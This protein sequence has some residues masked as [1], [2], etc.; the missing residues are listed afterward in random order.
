MEHA[1]SGPM[2][3]V[4]IRTAVPVDTEAVVAVIL[5]I[6]QEEFGIPITREAQ[7]DL[8]RIADYYQVRDGNFW[9]AEAGGIIVGTI[10]L[11]DI[12]NGEGALRKMFVSAPWRGPEARVAQ[13]LLEELLTWARRKALRRICLGT[14]DRFLAAHRFYEKHGFELIAKDN[15]PASFPVMTVDTRF[16]ALRLD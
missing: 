7:P 9:V 15:L 10:G 2:T 8:L 12:G 5:P 1:L 4:A 6:Q 13:R 11:L 3:E 16:Y 14:T